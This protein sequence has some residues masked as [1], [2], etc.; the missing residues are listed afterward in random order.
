MV[1][2]AVL[3][4]QVTSSAVSRYPHFCRLTLERPTPVLRRLRHFHSV[5]L[6]SAPGGS[7]SWGFSAIDVAVGWVDILS[8]HKATLVLAAD[9]ARGSTLLRK[10][11]LDFRRLAAGVWLKTGWRTSSIWRLRSFMLVTWR[12]ISGGAMPASMYRLSVGVGR[13]HPVIW[14]QQ[15]LRAVSTFFA[16]VDLSHTGHAYSAAE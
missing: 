12:L 9:V 11:F 6:V 3:Q 7:S 5:H 8:S 2:G 10:L 4:S 13:R 15:A 1:W 16:W 14:R